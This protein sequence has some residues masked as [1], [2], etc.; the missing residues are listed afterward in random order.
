MREVETA[1]SGNPYPCISYPHGLSVYR[2][3]S[4]CFLASSSSW[5]GNR[6]LA[7]VFKDWIRASSNLFINN[8]VK[9]YRD[10]IDPPI[11]Y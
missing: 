5:A 1:L 8:N 10:D 4:P 6:I 3:S 11:S 9:A 7:C 2:H